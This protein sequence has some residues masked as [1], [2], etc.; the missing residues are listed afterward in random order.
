MAGD[1]IPKKIA[2]DVDDDGVV[3]EDREF[4]EDSVK[5]GGPFKQSKSGNATAADLKNSL[6]RF[7]SKQGMACL[8][9]LNL[10]QRL[11]KRC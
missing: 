8:C 4:T 6:R 3:G 1:V 5:T 7:L 11:R 2:V 10:L 9:N